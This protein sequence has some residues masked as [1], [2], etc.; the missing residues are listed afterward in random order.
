MMTQNIPLQRLFEFKM[1]AH[2]YRYNCYYNHCFLLSL[3]WDQVYL[4]IVGA[5]Y[6]IESIRMVLL[7]GAYKTP[8]I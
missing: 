3:L 1:V 6:N 7:G 2:G 5:I 8:S 4:T